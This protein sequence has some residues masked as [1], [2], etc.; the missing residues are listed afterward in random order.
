[1]R[2]ID[3]DEF[4]VVTFTG[5]SLEFGDGAMAVL[6]MLDAAPSI[7]AEPVRH[8]VWENIVDFGGGDCYG[9]CSRCHTD[10]KAQNP[11]ALKLSY[12]YCRW[13]GAKMDAKETS[14]GKIH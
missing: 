8:G 13:C 5:K 3:A 4:E 6:E 2:L 14:D 1:M 9:Y 7:E 12:R 10:H 11:T